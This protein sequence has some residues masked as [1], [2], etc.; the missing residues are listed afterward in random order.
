M[1][2]RRKYFCTE[3]IATALQAMVSEDD[4]E[5]DPAAWQSVSMGWNPAK[6]NPNRCFNDLRGARGVTDA[7][8]LGKTDEDLARSL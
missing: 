5:H 7:V 8:P 6:L 2:Q 1:T 3:F 4:R